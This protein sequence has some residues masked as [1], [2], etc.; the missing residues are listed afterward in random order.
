[1][2]QSRSAP[3]IELAKKTLNFDF[4]DD[5][6]FLFLFRSESK[7][8]LTQ[9]NSIFW[10]KQI[11]NLEKFQLK[12][13]QE[14]DLKIARGTLVVQDYFPQVRAVAEHLDSQMDSGKTFEINDMNISQVYAHLLSH[15][16]QTEKELRVRFER[17]VDGL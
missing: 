7:F 5:W 1:M 2:S 8:D 14:V 15:C 4:P 12:I 10:Q 11:S 13:G 17:K 6:S 16:D 3:H 9:P